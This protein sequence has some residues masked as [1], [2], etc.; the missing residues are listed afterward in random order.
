MLNAGHRCNAI[1]IRCEKDGSRKSFS[2]YC[3][4]ALASI[5]ELNETLSDRSILIVMQRAAPNEEIDRF[6]FRSV[7][8]EADPLRPRIANWLL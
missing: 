3:P 4:K 7:R 8:H 2:V 6:R 1:A 5:G